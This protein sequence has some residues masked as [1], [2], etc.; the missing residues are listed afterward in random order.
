MKR[1]KEAEEEE[2]EE[3]AEDIADTPPKLE[4]VGRTS[5]CVSEVSVIIELVGKNVA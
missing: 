1:R 3:K 5:S 2:E 4:L